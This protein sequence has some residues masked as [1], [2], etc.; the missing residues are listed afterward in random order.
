MGPR[1]LLSAV[2]DDCWSLYDSLLF[3]TRETPASSCEHLIT[4]NN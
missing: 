4:I 2:C 3:E 1:S